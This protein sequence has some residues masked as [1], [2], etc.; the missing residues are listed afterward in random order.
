[1]ILVTVCGAELFMLMILCMSMSMSICS[2]I[3]SKYISY[4]CIVMLSYVTLRYVF[5]SYSLQL[6]LAYTIYGA[7]VGAL[8]CRLVNQSSFKSSTKSQRVSLYFIFNYN[9]FSVHLLSYH[10]HLLLFV[11][12][13]PLCFRFDSHLT[14]LKVSYVFLFCFLFNLLSLNHK[15]IVIIIIN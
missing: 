15:K 8:N 10:H 5:I 7:S 12:N 13:F 9:L 6:F 1:M 4:I 11:F 14:F 3:Y 2:Y